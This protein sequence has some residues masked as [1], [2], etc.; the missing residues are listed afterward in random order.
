MPWIAAVAIILAAG[1]WLQTMRDMPLESHR[2]PLPTL[3]AEEDV[4]G[5]N[6][7]LQRDEEGS[8]RRL[9]DTA[10]EFKQVAGSECS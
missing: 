5:S 8:I 6:S 10:A 1:I 9:N 7:L 3:T 4:T 2:G